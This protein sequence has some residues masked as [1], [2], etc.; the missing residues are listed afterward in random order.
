MFEKRSKMEGWDKRGGDC[1]VA[2]PDTYWPFSRKKTWLMEQWGLDGMG[3][4]GKN[5]DD[6]IMDE[7]H[8]K[9]CAGL[10]RKKRLFRFGKG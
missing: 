7:D 9:T 8:H 1:W 3:F 2:R 6:V 5:R 4:G 10:T